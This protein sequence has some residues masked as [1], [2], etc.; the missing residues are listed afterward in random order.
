[1]LL[2]VI[3]ITLPLLGRGN[4]SK[5]GCL[6]CALS[7]SLSSLAL[8]DLRFAQLQLPKGT[9]L[10]TRKRGR[11]ILISL[12]IIKINVCPFASNRTHNLHTTQPHQTLF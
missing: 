2:G 10:A 7:S 12:Q 9:Q 4:K 3:L 11:M 8:A 5:L 1:M 6:L